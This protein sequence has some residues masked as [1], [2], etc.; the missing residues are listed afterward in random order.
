MYRRGYYA[1][2][3]ARTLSSISFESGEYLAEIRTRQGEVTD[4]ITFMTNR[5]TLTYGGDGGSGEDMSIPPN[6]NRRIVAFVGTSKGVLEKLGAISVSRNWEEIG[7]L[8]LLRA[9]VDKNRAAAL[10]LQ[11]DNNLSEE[12]DVVL[13]QLITNV[14]WDLFKQVISFLGHV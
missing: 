10:E 2:H 8:I 3:P 9:L 1:S 4:Q 6:L 11:D 7:P 13:Q 12:D 14:D 5:R